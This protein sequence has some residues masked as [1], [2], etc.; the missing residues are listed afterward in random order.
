MQQTAI[1]QNSAANAFGLPLQ[2]MQG[3]QS[4][5]FGNG[6]IFGGNGGLSFQT[7]LMMTPGQNIDALQNMPKGLAQSGFLTAGGNAA[8]NPLLQAQAATATDGAQ[9]LWEQLR[10]N[11]QNM[12]VPKTATAINAPAADIAATQGQIVTGDA[13]QGISEDILFRFNAPLSLGRGLSAQMS[14]VAN[15]NT[16]TG[17]AAQKNAVIGVPLSNDMIQHL[18]MVAQGQNGG[19][20]LAQNGGQFGNIDLS[21][22]S[23][24]DMAA[25]SSQLNTTLDNMTLEQF[26]DFK[27]AAFADLAPFLTQAKV[28]DM[29]NGKIMKI[30]QGPA[31]L[32][33]DDGTDAAGLEGMMVMLMPAPAQD[34]LKA[35]GLMGGSG[36]TGLQLGAQG[37]AGLT[38]PAAQAMADAAAASALADGADAVAGNGRAGTVSIFGKM[39]SGLSGTNQQSTVHSA[40]LGS[41]ALNPAGQGTSAAHMLVFDNI[42]TTHT[43]GVHDPLMADQNI[44]AMIKADIQSAAAKANTLVHTRAAGY[45]HPT[46]QGVAEHL[47]AMVSRTPQGDRQMRLQL[48][49]PELGNVTIQIKFGKDNTVKA[50]LTV[51]RPETLHLLQKDSASL[52]KALQEAGI[53]T[54]GSSLS[55]DLQQ[56]D[57][58]G[59]KGSE[60]NG[61]GNGNGGEAG[62]LEVNEPTVIETQM[63]V[64]VDPVTGQQRVNMMV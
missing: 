60:Q 1:I 58:G 29:G 26:N 63:T 30:T 31:F 41:S 48:D 15:G 53:D 21:N 35:A 42:F 16:Q 43:E 18:I 2:G 24:E 34:A 28:V 54:D 37:G 10:T 6:L 7:F 32:N 17:Q 57:Q 61:K 39:L 23:A 36:G 25:L 33:K 51:E 11:I 49:P 27:K 14:Q 20:N 38:D 5:A 52:E 45:P 59:D 47:T 50:H 8:L 64:F 19:Q 13:T 56:G 22:M 12:F 55:F 46:S 4:G 3:G 9:P 62:Q 44:D 40:L